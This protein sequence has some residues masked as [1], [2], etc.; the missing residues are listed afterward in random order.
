MINEKAAKI[1]SPIAIEDFKQ[2]L[3]TGSRYNNTQNS[4]KSLFSIRKTN[5]IIEM[6]VKSIRMNVKKRSLTFIRY[7]NK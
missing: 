6:V 2:F 3:I 5:L 7:E 4:W 1:P